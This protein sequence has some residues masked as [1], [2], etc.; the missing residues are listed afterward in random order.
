M[1]H[2]VLGSAMFWLMPLSHLVLILMTLGDKVMI[3]VLI[4]KE[5]IRGFK[6]GCVKLIQEPNVLVIVL[7]LLFV[8]WPSLALKLSLFWEMTAKEIFE[9]VTEG[10]CYPCTSIAYRI[11]FTMPVTV[12]SA[13]RSFSKLKLLKNYLRSTMS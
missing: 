3:M 13:E 12:A 5:N 2:L 6:A 1:A 11:L 8:I 4:W 9:F 7:I 10:D